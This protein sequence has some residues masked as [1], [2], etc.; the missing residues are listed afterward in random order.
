VAVQCDAHDV[1]KMQPGKFT[2]LSLTI[3]S[4]NWPSLPETDKLW[5]TLPTIPNFFLICYLI[6]KLA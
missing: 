6:E 4:I 2:A 1:T 3:G 5:L